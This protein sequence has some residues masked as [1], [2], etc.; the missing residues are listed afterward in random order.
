MN[1]KD[2]TFEIDDNQIKFK[3]GIFMYFMIIFIPI[4]SL[5]FSKG[6]ILSIAASITGLI[7]AF[8]IIRLFIGFY[9]KH[10]IKL[11]DIEYVKAQIWDIS[12]DKI[13]DFW[14]TG[15]YKY[16]FPTGLNKKTNPKVIFVHIKDRKAA[17]GF[18]PENCENA[19][20]VLRER[21]I[22]IIEE[23]S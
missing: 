11:S 1:Y 22:K 2:K 4:F 18:V 9:F 3:N 20:S 21:G 10:T 13:R 5:I 17:V 15:R 23:I 6:N 12:I 8:F 14:G 16:H 7:I 19:I